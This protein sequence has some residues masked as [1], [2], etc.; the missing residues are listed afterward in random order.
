MKEGK[1]PMRTFGD[2][3]QFYEEKCKPPEKTQKPAEQPPTT[4]EEKA[5]ASTEITPAREQAMQIDEKAPV[6]NDEN[7]SGGIIADPRT[8]NEEPT[9]LNV[10]PDHHSEDV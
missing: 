9:L 2:L 6:T 5:V 10:E 7:H 8:Q 4:K 1:E 3:V